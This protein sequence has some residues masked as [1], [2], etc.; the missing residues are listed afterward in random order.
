MSSF[1]LLSLVWQPLSNSHIFYRDAVEDLFELEYHDI[2][3]ELVPSK[4]RDG[5]IVFMILSIWMNVVTRSDWQMLQKTLSPT[6]W[7]IITVLLKSSISEIQGGEGVAIRCQFLDA[8]RSKLQRLAKPVSWRSPVGQIFN[9]FWQ[10]VNIA[11]SF[12]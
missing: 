2:K 11:N 1:I 7:R 3:N 10:G 6:S 4:A 8:Q 9:A 12:V 5:I